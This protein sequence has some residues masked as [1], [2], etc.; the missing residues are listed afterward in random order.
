[1]KEIV[2]NYLTVSLST[3]S[4]QLNIVIETQKIFR[5]FRI[6]NFRFLFEFQS[7]KNFFDLVPVRHARALLRQ[8]QWVRQFLDVA[9]PEAVNVAAIA[10]LVLKSRLPHPV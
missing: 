4:C 8:R 5:T 7:S 9:Q 1:M 2:L 6:G 10:T 3:I